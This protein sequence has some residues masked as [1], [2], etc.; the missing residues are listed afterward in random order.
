MKN[1]ELILSILV[2][3]LTI[4]L[5]LI[6]VPEYENDGIKFKNEYEKLNNKDIGY[7]KDYLEMYSKDKRVF[8]KRNDI[9]SDYYD[10]FGCYKNLCDKPF[11]KFKV[12]QGEL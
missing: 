5:V 8:G 6:K 3:L 9:C 11:A 10:I 4:I 7:N 2:S 12:I 1:K